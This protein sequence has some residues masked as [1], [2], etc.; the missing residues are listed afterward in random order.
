MALTHVHV[1]VAGSGFGGLGTAIRLKQQGI[2][3]FLVFE[4]AGDLGGTLRDNSYPGCTCDVPSHLYSFSFA[5]NPRWSRSFS[6][7]PEIWEYLRRCAVRF[8]VL[9]HLRFDHE[10]RAARWD[11]A[12]R[13][14]HIET[15]HGEFTA[16]VFV[17]ATRPLSEPSIPNV[18]SLPSFRGT[19][20]H[21]ARGDHDHDLTGRDVAV[22]GT[23]ASA[24][25]F[26]PH[27]QPRVASLR[28]FQRTA[29]WVMPR[30]DRA[31]TQAELALFRTFP[32]AQRAVRASIYWARELYALGFLHP[33][34]AGAA[35]A[36]ALR[37]LRKSLPD[38]ALR[39]R[40][41]P[42]YTIGCKRV[43]LS[44]DYLPALA[45][46]NVE[47]VTSAVREVR[48]EGILTADGV[49][50]R[51]D[52]IIFGTGF[53][54][55]DSPIADR[56]RGRDGRTLAEVWRGSP[57]AYLGTTVTGF[58][59]LFLLL[60]P[61]TGLGHTSVVFMA[62]CQ[63]EYVL[64][65]L[66][67]MHRHGVA[68]LEPRRDAQQE[69][70]S[71]V[72]TRMHNTVWLAGGCSSWYLDRTGRVSA[73]WPGFTWAYRRRLRRFDPGDYLPTPAGSPSGVGTA[74]PAA[75]APTP[76]VTS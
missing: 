53:H 15:S 50:H 26:V 33:R 41:V 1:A 25:Q 18:P 66:R 42:D 51:V 13:R 12:Y 31:L 52:T 6:P 14:W 21:S 10:V 65:A 59:N 49:E 75:P 27:I 57:Q 69:F 3:D 4:R 38:P 20:F 28:I 48:P 23:G 36:V 45:R 76:Q 63:I 9:P 61:N 46:A 40:L 16:D 68:A 7:Q 71:G 67:F 72:D 70:V 74:P 5:L 2:D 39:E 44:S 43:L 56:I 8:G 30:R 37:H 35:Q 17:A 73:I 29:P 60:G 58:P 34:L 55:T 62:E 24:I 47:L 32:P 54:V 64:R 11:D 22:I 19:A